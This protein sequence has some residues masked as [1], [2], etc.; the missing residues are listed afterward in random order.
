LPEP[1]PV[2][3]AIFLGVFIAEKSARTAARKPSLFHVTKLQAS[4]SAPLAITTGTIPTFQRCIAT[5]AAAHTATANQSAARADWPAEKITCNPNHTARFNTTPTTDAVTAVSVLPS[6]RLPRSC[7]IC[8]APRKIQ[9]K[10]VTKV[11]T[12]VIAPRGA[13][14]A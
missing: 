8:G 2:T 11:V 7:S 13:P 14:L 10:H 9:R 12:V 3:P 1:A 4:P 5:T 6:R